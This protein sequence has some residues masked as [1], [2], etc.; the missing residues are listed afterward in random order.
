MSAGENSA[1]ES[2][3]SSDL[4]KADQ[5]SEEEIKSM[6]FQVLDVAESAVTQQGLSDVS[7]CLFI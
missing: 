5:E 2:E 6:Y 3:N 7:F 4:G 1:A